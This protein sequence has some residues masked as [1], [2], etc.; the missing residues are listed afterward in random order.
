MEERVVL[1]I[2]RLGE[3][4]TASLLMTISDRWPNAT[5]TLDHLQFDGSFWQLCDRLATYYSLLQYVSANG[6][7][8][9]R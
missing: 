3:A 6:W 8:I 7:R 1:Q 5:P 9:G 4:S 2:V